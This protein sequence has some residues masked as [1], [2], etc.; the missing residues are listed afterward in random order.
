MLMRVQ[1]ILTILVVALAFGTIAE[2]QFRVVQL[3]SAA[4]CAAVSGLARNHDLSLLFELLPA[5]D[6]LRR[7]VPVVSG[8]QEK[9]DDGNHGNHQLHLYV[10]ASCDKVIKVNSCLGNGH[11]FCLDREHK[12]EIKLCIRVDDAEGQEQRSVQKSGG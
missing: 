3:G 12:E 8:H 1:M 7:I 9:Q 5:F 4:H 2:L 6:L 10:D 11:P